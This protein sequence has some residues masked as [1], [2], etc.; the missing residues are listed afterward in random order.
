MNIRDTIVRQRRE[1]ITRDGHGMGA[2][3]PPRRI[4]ARAV[5]GA[6]PL[7]I[8]EVKRRSPSRG[9]IAVGQDAVAQA[10]GYG[11]L[12][13]KSVSVLTEQDNFG[14]SLDDLMLIKEAQPDLA[15]LRKDFLLDV[16]D[17]EVS[18]RCG[19]D[20]VLLIASIIESDTL[21]AMHARALA[22]GMA[23]LVEVHDQ[24]DLDKCRPFAP[25]LLGVN[26]RDLTTFEI[27]LLLPLALRPKI[28]WPSQLVFES[29]V[30]GAEDVLLARSGGFSGVL[31]GETVMRHPELIPS[32][33]NAFGKEA[34]GFWPRL[35]ARYRAGRPL[36][37]VCGITNVADAE[38]AASYGADALGFV[39]APSTRRAAPEL[40][41]DLRDLRVLK[42]GVV[43]TERINDVPVL[44]D[45]T[46]ALLAEG[47]LDAVQLHGAER[48]RECPEI[49][50]PYFKAIRARDRA[51]VDA[52]AGF[53]CPRILAD[54]YSDTATGGTGKRIPVDLVREIKKTRPLWLAG[55]IGPTNV[56][57]VIDAFAPELIDASSGLE[58]SS[59]RKDPAKL[60]TFFQEIQR[61]E[62]N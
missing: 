11:E 13:V 52:M 49:A 34:P 16:E 33:L 57:E 29:G 51:D 17:V 42:V 40:L 54:A 41:R 58:E 1:R 47:L 38:A 48:P 37:K 30:R 18:F 62:R 24:D 35:M 55:G 36:V 28:T 19:A 26:C 25:P 56:G 14:G 46:K 9:D 5:F 22:L 10:Q 45:A 8:C 7:L 32:L 6:D 4:A 12:G 23:A 20:A 53:G 61:H 15:V 50:F 3:V 60:A 59:G 43:V 44:D 31:V 21:R 2:A 27:D 39:F